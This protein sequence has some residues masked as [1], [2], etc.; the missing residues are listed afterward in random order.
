VLQA[1]TMVSQLASRG[2]IMEGT[3]ALNHT[4]SQAEWLKGRAAFI[5]CGTWLENEMKD[6][7]P[8]GFDMVIAPIPALD[9]SK[10]PW[11]AASSGETYFV[12]AKA[13]HPEAG[14]EYMRCM[15]SKEN[16]KFFAQNVSSMMPVIGG[17]EGLDLSPGMTSAIAAVEAAGADI[18]KRPKFGAWYRDLGTEVSG[19]LGE[20]LTGRM[21]PEEFIAKAQAKADEVAA[22]DE[23]TKFSR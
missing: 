20:I 16:A 18:L 4:E 9:A 10:A 7:T 6:V 23:I 14:M 1:V 17:T 2:D 8:E 3:E 11:I 22:D 21:T 13:R 15:L 5:P 19:N 12:P